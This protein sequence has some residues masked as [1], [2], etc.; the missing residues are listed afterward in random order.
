MY[1]I[2]R[3][4]G[5]DASIYFDDFAHSNDDPADLLKKLDSLLALML[6]HNAKFSCYKVRLEFPEIT[7]LGF[8]ISKKG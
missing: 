3:L 5:D 4:L 8:D 1:H 2:Y 7:C 6:K